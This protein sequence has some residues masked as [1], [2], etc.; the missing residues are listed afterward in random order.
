MIPIP[1]N[2][3]APAI[4]YYLLFSIAI[5]GGVVAVVSA[6]MMIRGLL[7]KKGKGYFAVW[8]IT[9]LLMAL[10]AFLAVTGQLITVR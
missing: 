5:I 4:L 1:A 9:F 3:I 2:W 10:L 8:L 6:C 7:R